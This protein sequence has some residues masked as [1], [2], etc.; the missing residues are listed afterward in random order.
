MFTV[1]YKKSLKYAYSSH[2]NI[3]VYAR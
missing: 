3:T 1:T 2:V